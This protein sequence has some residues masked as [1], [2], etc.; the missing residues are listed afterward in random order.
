MQNT[1]IV[2]LNIN[3]LLAFYYSKKNGI[4][5]KIYDNNSWSKE[6]IV[7]INALENYSVTLGYDGIIYIFCQDTNGN[8]NLCI[9]KEGLWSSKVI[10]E[11]KSNTVHTIIFN[12]IVTESGLTLIYNVPS[13]NESGNYLVTQQLSENSKWSEPNK[14][15]YFTNMNNCFYQVQYIGK[16]HLLLFYQTK[17]PENRIGYRELTSTTQGPFNLFHMSTSYIKDYS[18]LTTN[19]EIHAI[20]IIK[21][22]FSSQL[23]YKKKGDDGFSK[24]IVLWESQKIENCL[25]FIIKN[26]IYVNFIVNGQLS[27][28]TSNDGGRT[29]S[30]PTSSTIKFN[31]KN[32]KAIF[33]S[34]PPQNENSYYIRELYVD[35]ENPCDIQLIPELTNDFLPVFLYTKKD[36]I[37]STERVMTTQPSGELEDLKEKISKLKNQLYIYKK[38]ISDKDKQLIN[39]TNL[40]KNRNEDLSQNTLDNKVAHKKYTDEIDRLTIKVEAFQDERANYTKQI[41]ELNNKILE[42]TTPSTLKE[43]ED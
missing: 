1:Y 34:E 6:Q 21:S 18:F 30:R 3:K 12:P 24:P 15:D 17:T 26:I 14:I 39:L 4:V 37:E 28:S 33:I 41:M 11:N 27:V 31:Y 29:F 8:L 42:L 20:Y 35:S 9:N 32:T 10:L 36:E 23:I 19:T 16:D 40:L 5:Y 38:Q 2:K 22:M 7:F 25:L 43:D 13:T